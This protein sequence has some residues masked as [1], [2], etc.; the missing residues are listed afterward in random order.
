MPQVDLSCDKDAIVDLSCVQFLSPCQLAVERVIVKLFT[1]HKCQ[2]VIT[3]R[4]RSLFT[5]KLWRMG[6][7]LCSLGGKA[8]SKVYSKWAESKWTIQLYENEIIQRFGSKRKHE[9]VVLLS[10]KKRL[11]EVEDDLIKKGK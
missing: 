9:N 8:R 7:L 1:H 5:T 11:T 2:V 6:K 4:L 10:S 3:D